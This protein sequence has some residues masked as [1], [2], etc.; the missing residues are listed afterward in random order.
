MSLAVD[1]T[2]VEQTISIRKKRKIHL[3]DAIIAATA[4]LNNY[5]LVT[6]NIKDFDNIKGL[7]LINPHD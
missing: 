4:T 7:R 1:D 2:V 6:R 5:I 3:P